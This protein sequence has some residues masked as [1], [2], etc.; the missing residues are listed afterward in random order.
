MSLYVITNSTCSACT[1]FKGRQHPELADKLAGVINYNLIDVN[2]LPTIQDDKVKS[3]KYTFYPCLIYS[4]EDQV[5]VFNG[6]VTQDGTAI[7]S[8]T[9]GWEVQ[10]ILKWLCNLNM[11]GTSII[12][13]V[14]ENGMEVKIDN[15]IMPL[16]NQYSSKNVMYHQYT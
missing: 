12:C 15:P 6:S 13:H 5:F 2:E 16:M 7:Y 9:G 4:S 1:K 10:D 11:D 3:V 14:N 8:G